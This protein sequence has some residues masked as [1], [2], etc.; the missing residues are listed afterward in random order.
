MATSINLSLARALYE[1]Q[2]EGQGTDDVV[3]PDYPQLRDLLT[4]L[5]Y[6]MG[7]HA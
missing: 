6:P 5:S 7:I 4:D 3:I 2:K 1:R